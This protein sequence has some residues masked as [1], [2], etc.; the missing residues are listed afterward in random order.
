ME[1]LVNGET[2]ELGAQQL[3]EVLRELGYVSDQIVVAINESFVPKAEWNL[4]KLCEH[5][6]LEVLSAIEGG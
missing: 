1:V 5:D 4:A 3:A 6:R 2:V